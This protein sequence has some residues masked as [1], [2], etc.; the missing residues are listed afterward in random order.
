MKVRFG[1]A[2][3]TLPYA[4]APLPA[5]AE[6]PELQCGMTVRTAEVIVTGQHVG[7]HD[8]WEGKVFVATRD[9]S[10][11]SITCRFR[12]N[13]A[14]VWES[15]PV[16]GTAGMFAGQ[17]DVSF[18]AQPIDLV[19]VCSQRTFRSGETEDEACSAWWWGQLPWWEAGEVVA[20]AWSPVS[21]VLAAQMCGAPTGDNAIN[22]ELFGAWV[23]TFGGKYGWF[24]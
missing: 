3:L 20:G 9:E 7:N 6:P 4:V 24:C 8:E 10:V 22:R 15:D 11:A 12:V 5:H 18:P 17:W 2:L 21:G 13:H 1:F 23:G 19:E 14:V 16:S